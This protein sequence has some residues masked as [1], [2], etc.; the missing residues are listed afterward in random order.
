MLDQKTFIQNIVEFPQ[1]KRTT[2]NGKRHYHREGDISR[3]YPS[4]TSITSLKSR[5]SIQ[6]WRAR[7]GEAEANRITTKAT[8]QGT[9][10]HALIEHYLV[11]DLLPESMPNEYELFKMFKAQADEHIDNIRTIEGQMMSDYLRCAG[12]VDLIADYDGKISII[13][14]KTSSRPKKEEWVTGYFMQESAYAVMFEENTNIPV[15]QLVTIVACST[16]EVQVFKTNRDKWIGEF[17]RY[18]DQY[19]AEN[20]D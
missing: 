9:K 6:E 16:G 20:N 19:E 1:L 2:I 10:A 8:R 7:V 12:T 14:W 13:D 18:R 3:A 5:K 15:S 17:I 11:S 4:V